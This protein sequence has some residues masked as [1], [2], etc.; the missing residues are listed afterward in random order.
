MSERIP[1]V[2][3]YHSRGRAVGSVIDCI[4]FPARHRGRCTRIQKRIAA[5]AATAAAGKANEGLG[6]CEGGKDRERNGNAEGKRDVYTTRVRS[7]MEYSGGGGETRTATFSRRFLLAARF[8]RKASSSLALLFRSS[9]SLSIVFRRFVLFISFSLE[10]D[11]D[12][13][14]RGERAVGCR[15]DGVVE[16]AGGGRRDRGML[17]RRR[18]ER[19]MRVSRL[20]GWQQAV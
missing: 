10:R 14:V 16:G 6:E 9:L 2:H 3:R 17:R 7:R 19:T 13:E 11:L 1:T 12:G 15:G 4:N 5:A 20:S 8:R 18:V